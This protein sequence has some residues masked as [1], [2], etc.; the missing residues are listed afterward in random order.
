MGLFG[1]T[2]T[3]AKDGVLELRDYYLEGDEVHLRVAPLTWTLRNLG[4]KTYLSGT[5][6]LKNNLWQNGCQVHVLFVQVNANDIRGLQQRGRIPSTLAI[7]YEK[8]GTYA[9]FKMLNIT[10]QRVDM[11]MMLEAGIRYPH[12]KNLAVIGKAVPNGQ[13]FGFFPW[14]INQLLGKNKY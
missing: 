11:N 5:W 14:E 8:G 3:M 10:E 4:V 13:P 6:Y 9:W 1:S 2:I 7:S 12:T